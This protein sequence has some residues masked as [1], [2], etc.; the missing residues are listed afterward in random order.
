MVM[1]GVA[2]GT[3]VP[4]GVE[5]GMVVGIIVGVGEGASAVVLSGVSGGMWTLAVFVPIFSSI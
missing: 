5:V 4:T 2:F 1:P 3:L